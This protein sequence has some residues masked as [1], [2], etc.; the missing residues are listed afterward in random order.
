MIG[1]AQGSGDKVFI[2]FVEMDEGHAHASPAAVDG[3]EG[4]WLLGDE[5]LLLL[6]RELDHP[7][8]FFLSGEGC[9]DASVET[10]VGVAH[11]RT[12]GGSWKLE[13]EAAEELDA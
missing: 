3:G 2:G 8:T 4:P 6:W 5:G 1:G 12:L 11:V 13:G 9:E 10:E 7:A